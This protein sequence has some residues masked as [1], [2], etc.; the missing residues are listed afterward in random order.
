M[1]KL[2]IILMVLYYS[3]LSAQIK[4][5]PT[6]YSAIQKAIDHAKDGDIIIVEEG[7]YHEQINFKGKAITVASMFYIDDNTSHISRTIIDGISLE[8]KDSNSL[9]YFI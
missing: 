5:V 1:R 3:I 4:F 8:E 7:T 6:N 9:V 2:Y